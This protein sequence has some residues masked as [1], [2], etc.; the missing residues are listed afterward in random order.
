MVS[1]V[2]TLTTKLAMVV[3]T[4]ALLIAVAVPKFLDWTKQGDM[5]QEQSES[6]PVPTDPVSAVEKSS[7]GN[8]AMMEKNA[9]ALIEVNEA[10]LEDL[11]MNHQDGEIRLV[12][13]VV[14]QDGERVIRVERLE[15]LG[16]SPHSKSANTVVADQEKTDGKSSAATIR[17][18]PIPDY[19][20][21]SF[22]GKPP[23]A[24]KTERLPLSDSEQRHRI[25][26]LFKKHPDL[27]LV[28]LTPEAIRQL[29][30]VNLTSPG[31]GAALLYWQAPHN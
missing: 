4:T 30:D 22:T 18:G 17:F 2:W 1:A 14:G 21:S 19:S 29:P 20:R 27:K 9:K 31:G 25:E 7:G 5:N 13:T 3:L 26:A 8:R 15:Q 23:T 11:R 6:D 10:I 24:I 12:A 16:N 28:E